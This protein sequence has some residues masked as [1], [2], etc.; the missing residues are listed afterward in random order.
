[1]QHRSVYCAGSTPAI[2]Y[3]SEILLER[4]IPV[5]HHPSEDVGYILLDVPSFDRDGALRGGGNL[6]ELL[7]QLPR[8]T[9]ICGGNLSEFIPEGYEAL[10]LLQDEEYLARNAAITAY[11]TIQIAAS[12]LPVTLADAPTLI[13]GW[14]RIGKCLARLLKE[15]GASVTV[16]ARNPAHRAAL[17]SLGYGTGETEAIH[18]QPFRLIVNTVPEMLLTADQLGECTRALKLDLASRRGLNS[19]DAIWA[20]GLPGIHAPESSGRLI[21]DTLI[22][23]M[24]EVRK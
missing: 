11:C 9:V 10:D 22:G 14:G 3:A 7:S 6:E 21:A 5:V 20:R 24:R 19:P 23:L 1:M 8:D 4:G 2:R 15:L 17:L 18:L 16:T 12:L 13:V